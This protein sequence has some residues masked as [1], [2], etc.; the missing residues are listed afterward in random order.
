VQQFIEY[1]RGLGALG[2]VIYTLGY[3]VFGLVVPASVLTIG[4]GALFGFVGGS[5]VVTIG[6]TLTAT[7]AFT[8]AR[9][10]LRKRVERMVSR[11]PKFAAVDRA[12]AREGPKIVILIR[13]AA[14]F[15]FLFVNYAFG[16]T[17]IRIGPYVIATL[18]GILPGVIA[19]VS[20]GAAGAA[21]ATASKT[22]MTFLIVGALFALA[23]SIYVG[24]VAKRALLHDELED[25][26]RDRKVNQ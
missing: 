7:I 17:G 14:V 6:A 8:L 12:I 18:I 16:L 23:A 4:A 1:V 5:I 19:F 26:D 21:A 25:A 24:R 15:P 9:T 22:K 13:L 10:V 3:A 2:Y 11:N 20:L